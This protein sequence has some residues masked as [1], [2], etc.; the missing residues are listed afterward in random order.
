MVFILSALWGIRI[1]G[2]WKLP[3][4]RD[5]LRGKLGLVLTGGA[6]LSKS[7]IQFSVDGRGCV[8]SL[9]LD[10]RPNY[11]GGNE[12]NSDLLQKVPCTHCCTQCPWPCSRPLP[13]PASVGDSW[14]LTGKSGSASCGLTAPFSWVLVCTRFVCALQES[15]SPVL[16]K[17]CNQIPLASKVKFSGGVLSP[18]AR[19]PGWEICCGSQNFLNS[20]II[21][22]GIIVLQFVGHLLGGS[23]V[24]LTV[25]SSTRAYATPSTAAPRAPAPAAG[26][27]W[28]LPP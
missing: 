6:M 16:W 4:G 7:L 20:A 12:G 25:T 17:F 14:T 13:T 19:S 18:F 21:F 28:P 8:P 9:L 22:F 3:E 23:V 1:R 24:G 2:L 5:W 10:L 15:V 27:C 26:P 11:G